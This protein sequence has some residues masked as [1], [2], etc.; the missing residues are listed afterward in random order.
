MTDEIEKRIESFSDSE[1]MEQVAFRQSEFTDTAREV[2]LKVAAHRG[3]RDEAVR[4]L[5][6]ERVV[7]GDAKVTCTACCEELVLDREEV[8]SGRFT[9]PA[10]AEKLPVDYSTLVDGQDIEF[11]VPRRQ[12][13]GDG[14]VGIGGWLI[15]VAVGLGL[16]LVRSLSNIVGAVSAGQGVFAPSFYSVYTACLILLCILMFRKSW[17]FPLLFKIWLAANVAMGLMVVVVTDS[18]KDDLMS[19]LSTVGY[20]AIWISYM[21]VSKRVQATFV[22]KRTA[23]DD[24]ATVLPGTAPGTSVD[25]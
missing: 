23:A 2:L 9:C 13:V 19:L 11:T 1:L 12:G 5:R 21:T 6:G 14:P 24:S 16:G 17:L 25:H 3:I 4:Q 15:V 18:T 8:L 20:A 7:A 22:R 10:C